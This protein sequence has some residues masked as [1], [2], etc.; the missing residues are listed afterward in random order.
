MGKKVWI[1]KQLNEIAETLTVNGF[2][3]TNMLDSKEK[4]DAIIYYSDMS[5]FQKAE[6]F[7]N[8]VYKNSNNVIKINAANTNIDEIM[9][10]LNN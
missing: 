7:S 4:L 9:R 2:E 1:E 3:V 10:I 6:G 8:R 5:D